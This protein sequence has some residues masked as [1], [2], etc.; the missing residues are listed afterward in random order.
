M[1][2]IP[3]FGENKVC[4]R[5]LFLPA[6]VTNRA[7]VRTLFS[8]ARATNRESVRT[9]FGVGLL[10]E[11]SACSSFVGSRRS[12]MLGR[13]GRRTKYVNELCFLRGGRHALVAIHMSEWPGHE[14]TQRWRVSDG[15]VCENTCARELPRGDP[16]ITGMASRPTAR[17]TRTRRVRGLVRAA[18]R[19]GSFRDLRSLPR[20]G[21]AA[22]GR[23]RGRV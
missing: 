21:R 23:G 3:R 11:Q 10:G 17:K 5:T 13:A 2:G 15:R 7:S 18:L 12:A 6:R 14:G 22:R 19:A 16:K 8:P 20:A 1:P 9:L 4:V